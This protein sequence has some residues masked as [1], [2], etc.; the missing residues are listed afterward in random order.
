MSKPNEMATLRPG[1]RVVVLSPPWERELEVTIEDIRSDPT[2]IWVHIVH[3]G[4]DAGWTGFPDSRPR[5][6]VRL[7]EC[8]PKGP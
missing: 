2:G 5:Y 8:R 4:P 1:D 6:R 3:D 7:T